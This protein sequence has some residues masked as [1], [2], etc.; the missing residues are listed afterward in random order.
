MT[1]MHIHPLYFAPKPG[2]YPFDPYVILVATP[3]LSERTQEALYENG[4]RISCHLTTDR[5]VEEAGERLKAEIDTAVKIA[6]KQRKHEYRD[7]DPKTV[8]K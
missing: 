3:L 1:L 5:E 8:K 6:K 2:E 7:W 4:L